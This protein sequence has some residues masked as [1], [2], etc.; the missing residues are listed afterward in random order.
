M[1]RQ[2][3]TARLVR[4][5]MLSARAQCKHLQFAAEG[6]DRFDFK[7]GQFVSMVAPNEEGKQI[8]RAYSI[9]SGPNGGPHFDLC[10]NRVEGGFFSNHLCDMKEGDTVQFHGPHG[11]FV[12][13]NPLRDCVMI[14]TGTGIAPMR[15]FVEWLFDEQQPQHQG[16]DIWLVYGTRYDTE[17]YYRDLFESVAKKNPN[18][19]YMV[20]LSRCGEEWTGCRGYVQD[21]VKAV[22]E[23][24][25]DRG[26]D[27]MDA[28]ICGL[29]LMVSANRQQLAEFGWE[30]KQIVFE[31]YD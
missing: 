1:A 27:T 15:G 2:L 16:R 23:A 22:L 7:A 6:M 14:A 8:T 9:A 30:K 18:F 25:P 10:L 29:N 20:T 24:R 4:E 12:L 21:H 17:I 3:Y 5:E 19:H 13:R 11:L 26:K 28:Y 31:R